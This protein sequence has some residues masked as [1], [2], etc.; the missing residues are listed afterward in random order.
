MVNGESAL[1]T[2]SGSGSGSG[3]SLPAST[4][5]QEVELVYWKEIKDSTD[6]EEFRAFLNKFPTGIYADLARKRLERIPVSRGPAAAPA[7]P[8]VPS[9]PAAAPPAPPTKRLSWIPM[10]LGVIVLVGAGVFIGYEKFS[11]PPA[12]L[13]V[14]AV[15]P[16][17]LPPSDTHPT[18]P[19]PHPKAAANPVMPAVTT[20]VAAPKT[21]E[22]SSAATPAPAAVPDPDKECEG[23]VLLGYLT[24]IQDQCAKAKFAAHPTCV[25]RRSDEDRSRGSP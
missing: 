11:S 9:A 25:Q 15:P 1:G 4:V 3:A 5:T 10:V 13:P 7:K 23:R 17:A 2:G 22:V 19:K 16:S 6:A 20:P 18:P 12:P 14:V 21:P 24:C 8:S